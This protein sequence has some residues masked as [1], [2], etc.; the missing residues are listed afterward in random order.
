MWIIEFLAYY[1]LSPW[2]LPGNRSLLNITIFNASSIGELTSGSNPFFWTISGIS[3][4]L[5]LHWPQIIAIWLFTEI[6]IFAWRVSHQLVIEFVDYRTKPEIKSSG[7]GTL[8]ST[9]SDLSDLLSSKL[10]RISELYRVVNEKRAILSESGAGRPIDA[11]INAEDISGLLTSAVSTDSKFS[12]GPL[13]IPASTIT[14]LIGVLCRG[15]RIVVGLHEKEN[16]KK[17]KAVFLTAHMMGGKEPHSW[18]VDSSTEPLEDDQDQETR[19][20]GDMVTELAH[21]IFAKLSYEEPDLVPWKAAW[22]FNEGLRNYRDC[23]HTNTQRKLFLFKA[24]KNFINSLKENDDFSPTYYNLGVVYTELELPDAAEAAF[25]K[26]IKTDEEEWR[27]YYALAL[28]IFKKNKIWDFNESQRESREQQREFCKIRDIETS[29]EESKE[30][31]KK[32]YNEAVCLCEHVVHLKEREASFVNKD[33]A[34][35][36]I[37]YNLMGDIQGEL[38]RYMDKELHL[39]KAIKN[40]EKAVNFSLRALIEAEV[41]KDGIENTVHIASE[42]L[43]DLAFLYIKKYKLNED[44]EK[45]EFWNHA[46]KAKMLLEQAI[47]IDPV[48][49][50]LY[51][52]LGRSYC[53]S[54]KYDDA[55]KNYKFALQIDPEN[56]QFWACLAGAARH[57]SRDEQALSAIDNIIIYGPKASR[58]VLEK[59]AEICAKLNPDTPQER[60]SLRL[61]RAALLAELGGYLD[62]GSFAIPDVKRKIKDLERKIDNREDGTEQDIAWRFSQIALTLKRLCQRLKEENSYQH[63]KL[64]VENNGYLDEKITGAIKLLKDK[65]EIG[66]RECCWVKLISEENDWESLQDILALWTLCFILSNKINRYKLKIFWRN[67]ERTFQIKVEISK[68]DLKKHRA[69]VQEFS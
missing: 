65:L 23:L 35:L 20:I 18:L 58:Y 36:A 16:D 13:S 40:C 38:S 25:R 68:G 34:N 28:N 42:C 47:Y 41:R 55:I 61:E 9:P 7:N 4:V 2:A 33:Y 10:A 69:Y 39:G 50:N 53:S 19:T 8:Q 64:C 11:T 15:P 51:L 17:G 22:Y 26:A 63:D 48:D 56:S 43:I 57:L 62:K 1:L 6:I 14:G 66:D 29:E 32:Q 49:A 67:I 37:A 46:A 52:E 27:A 45:C 59:A 5:W 31:I 12:L 60:N 3:A 54:K 24:E 44:S 21:R 30:I